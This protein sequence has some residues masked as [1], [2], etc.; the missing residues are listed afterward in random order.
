MSDIEKEYLMASK[1]NKEKMV[2][3]ERI[4]LANF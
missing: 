4:D 3:K 1:K 2:E